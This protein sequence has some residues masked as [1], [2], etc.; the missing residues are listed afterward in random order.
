MKMKLK[1]MIEMMKKNKRSYF[2]LVEYIKHKVRVRKLLKYIPKQTKLIKFWIDN[3]ADVGFI[4]ALNKSS[5]N[6]RE[7]AHR[8]EDNYDSLCS[9]FT[10]SSTVEGHSYW[11]TLND[12]FNKIMRG[13]NE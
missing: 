8:L 3:K 10:W 6:T 13:D 2:K 11:D 9:S 4:K 7:R 1:M 12:E 5:K